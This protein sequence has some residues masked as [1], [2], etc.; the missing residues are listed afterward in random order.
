MGILLSEYD[1]CKDAIIEPHYNE[2]FIKGFPIYG[3]TTFSK[4]IIDA[5]AKLDGVE[6][7]SV[8]HSGSGDVPIYKITYENAEIVF[9]QSH[10]GA[11]SCV[12]QYEEIIAKGL[13]KLV[14]FGACG[15]LDKDIADGHFIIPTSAMRD[16]GTSYHYYRASDE[17]SMT[18]DSVVSITK[19]MNK[20]GYPWKT[21]KTWTI[22]APYRE[23][24]A[25][26][27]KRKQQGCIA[28]EMECAAMLAVSRF[29][30]VGFGQFFYAADN[31]DMPKW[32][33]R[34]LNIHG[35]SHRERYMLVAFESVLNI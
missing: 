27:F 19:A 24:R 32:E 35:L 5:Y 11:P 18:N 16:E 30:D 17:I 13:R 29:R 1:P 7:I 20:Y 26:V 9:Y 33:P 3:V 15:V 8:F 31:V 14:M 4:S 34:S 2:G 22:D 28:V 23:T 10:V 12:L 25:K 6:Q 21:G